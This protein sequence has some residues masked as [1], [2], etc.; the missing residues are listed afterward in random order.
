MNTFIIAEVGVNHNGDM[1]L[2]EKLIKEAARIGSDAVKFQ[3]FCTENLVTK[4]AEKAAYQKTTTSYSESQFDML[5]KLELSESDFHILKSICD[6]NN[7][8]FMS[9]PFDENSVD[10]LE[11]IGVKNYKV[12]SGDITNKRLLQYIAA[13][14]KP[15]ILSTGMSNMEEIKEAVGWIK[16]TGNNAVAL[17]HCTSNYPARFEDI[18]MKA[19]QKLR[20]YFALPVGYSDHTEGILIPIMAVSLGATIIE[21]H[22]TISKELPGPDHQASLNI[23]EFKQM[24]DSIRNV[25]KAFGTAEKRPVKNE[26]NTLIAARKSVVVT[27]DLSQGHTLQPEDLDIKRPGN[28]IP[29]KYLSIL[30]GKKLIQTVSKDTTLHFKD[31]DEKIF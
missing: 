1:R 9:T 19:M 25:E 3:T 4:S 5:K 24:V 31:I 29:P 7:I 14:G 17:L 30:Y 23:S 26:Y 2:A 8:E 27:K 6:E 11:K 15:I 21:K 13:K 16:E 18:N 10:I 22:I 12:S 20:E 28:G